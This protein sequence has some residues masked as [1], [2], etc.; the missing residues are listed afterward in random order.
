MPEKTRTPTVLS[1]ITSTM[2]N[3]TKLQRQEVLLKTGALQN[4]ILSSANFSSIA[5]DAKGVIQIFNI[6]A[7][8][9]L[10]YAAAE[11]INKITP[12]DISDP[13][14]VISRAK[15]LST[16]LSTPIM[17]GFEALVFKASRGIEDIYELTYIRKDGS[18][19]PAVVSVTALRDAQNTIIGYLLIGTDNTARKLA[20]EELLKAGALQ[21]A[22]FSSANFSSI[23][24]DAK[25][26]I[27]I[28]N[29]GAEHMLGYAAAEVINK[30]TPADI[31]DPQEVISRAKAL[32]TELSTA[33]MP[34]F[35]ALVFKAS[36]GIED[37]YELTYIR[38]D[39]SRFP[40]VVSVTA[41]RD[42]KNT[43]IGY[44][45][46]GTDNTARKL[47]EEELLKAG[48]LQRAIFS[49]ANFSSIATDAK[50]VIQIFNVGAEHML[51]YRSVEVINKITPADISDP[52]E[53]IARANVLSA[54]LSTPIMP[55]F[56]AL[57]FKASR[58]IEDIYELTYIRKDGSRFPAVVSVTA[59][60]DAKNTIIGYLLIGTDNTARKLAE[61]ELLKA[62][63]LQRAIFSSA[64]FSSIATDANGVIQIFNV[65]AEHM[66]GYMAAEVINKIT[67]ADISDPLEVIARAK[68]LSIELSASIMP[69]FEA[70]VFKASRGIEDI[71]ELTYI[72]KDG[73]RFPAVVS[74]TAL[75]DAH[76]TII[77][78]LLIGTD[79]T[80]RKQV[81]AEQRKL[82]QR[83]RDQQ[84]YTRSLIE[85]NIEALMITDLSGIITDVN[86]QMEVLTGCTR[87]ELIG[88]PF[89]DYC[90]DP[91]RAEAGIKRVL[92]EKKVMDYDLTVRAWN[93]NETPVSLDAT[94]FYD[95][96]RKL[97]GVFAA[98]R[99]MTERKRLDQALQDK[100][101]ELESA[102]IMA[103]K[104]NLAKSDFLATMSHEIRTPINGVIGLT[105]LCLQTD[106]TRRQRDYLEKVRI[107]ANVLLQLIN[108]ILDFS[109]IE[110]GKL[111]M[112]DVEFVLEEVLSGI[113]TI[114]SVKSN[115]KGLELLLNTGRNVPHYLRGD[116][117]RLGQILINLVGNAI[118][119]T[120]KG[121][122]SITTE[123]LE[124][125]PDSVFLQFTVQDT[126]IGMTPEQISKLFQEFSQG[127]NSITR[128]Y[129]G[130]GLGL[131]ISKRLVEMMG[132]HINVLNDSEQGCRFIFTAYF[133]KTNRLTPKLPV[134]AKNICGLHILVVDDN[135]NARQ[136][137]AEH[138]SLLTYHPVC[139]ESGE[140][141]IETI[142]A[143][144]RE[145][146]CFDLVLID[147]KMPGMDG[148]ET[149][150]IIKDELS[151]KKIPSIIMVTAYGQ[152]Y[153][154]LPEDEKNIIDGF[155]MK[156]VNITSLLDSIMI[157]FGHKL[158]RQPTDHSNNQ[159][160]DFSGVRLLLAE[161]NEINQQVARELLERMGINVV[162]VSNGQEAVDFVA[163]EHVDGILMDLQM[164]I[165]DGLT[166]TRHIRK[167]ESPE[168]LPIIAMTA[169]AMA[170]DREKCLDAGMNDHISKPV[171]P[172]EMYTTLVKWL[173]KQPIL[174]PE[175][176]ILPLFVKSPDMISPLPPILGI[177]MARG[178][179]NVGGNIV[180]YRNVLLIFAKNQKGSCLEMEQCLASGNVTKLESIAHSLKGV[181]ATL[182]AS[183]L[184]DLAEEIEKRSKSSAELKELSKLLRSTSDELARIV[185]DIETTL[186]K[187]TTISTKEEQ[188]GVDA[189][190][191]E[192]TPLFEKAIALLL[193]SDSAVEEVVE[194]LANLLCSKPRREKLEAIKVALDAYEFEICLALFQDWKR[195]ENVP[196]EVTSP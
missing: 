173:C 11:V 138:L 170:G 195:E 3:I 107:S 64:N 109:K 59:L 137:L 196:I 35:E 60:R 9:M 191:E 132:G 62:G 188:L 45:L 58:G 185:S 95:R 192:L 2:E 103:E 75:R 91:E 148:L 151:L 117:H 131:A 16:E 61:E 14:E 129:G 136:I 67:P 71:Y 141:A 27:Q 142:I 39:G 56:E 139:V 68:A 102:K 193:S 104:A 100:N 32:S 153:V 22:I 10:G 47:A 180:L 6:G 149:A 178:M 19:F 122:V 127:D 51:G 113:V 65:G 187:Q 177:D 135:I 101:D 184:S 72:R 140:K 126:G 40:A 98:V 29:V 111:A 79:N 134:L 73:S 84:F 89:K 20:E 7:E 161:D 46:I 118:K 87:D 123:V 121:E 167:K 85:S 156:P 92:G 63:A 175:T 52:K 34:G 17:P 144:N 155:L 112:E 13:E 15:V 154:T 25:G 1:P 97:Q 50:G 53:L 93:S 99:N 163:M 164:P 49:S 125:R 179:H 12:A 186:T 147:W 86:K 37:I 152:D 43:I 66:L 189:G 106:L 4:A 28:F 171:D 172:E 181:S 169:N 77:G 30:I 165:M 176:H 150:R 166:A 54:E 42:A 146:S 38:K 18:R 5:T 83:L 69:G 24:T 41:L 128:K 26:V 33:I 90:T 31:S 160:F 130:T 145:D 57:V 116:S 82:D 8:H 194:E 80:A 94:T 183:T 81:E 108:D 168:V 78:Y 143:A 21:R 182:G 88:S 44:L 48:A 36:R 157:V 114:L 162:I 105:H 76:N 96:N 110:A 119:F 190:S 74:V 115:E 120:D 23:A 158:T 70:L 133:S 159:R 55:G 174:F 124:E